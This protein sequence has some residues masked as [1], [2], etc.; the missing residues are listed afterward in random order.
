MGQLEL[1]RELLRR[2]AACPESSLD[3][4]KILADVCRSLRLENEAREAEGRSKAPRTAAKP[5]GISLFQAP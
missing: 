2:A 5:A 1:A 4:N 3:A